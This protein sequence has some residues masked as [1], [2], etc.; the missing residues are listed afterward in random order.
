M[1]C[2]HPAVLVFLFGF[3]S[4]MLVFFIKKKLQKCRMPLIITKDVQGVFN[5]AF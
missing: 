3:L 5:E 1:R 4:T 2:F